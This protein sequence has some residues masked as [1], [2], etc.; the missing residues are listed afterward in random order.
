MYYYQLYRFQIVKEALSKGNGRDASIKG[1]ISS[2]L[3]TETDLAV[4]K[5]VFKELKEAYPNHK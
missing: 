3:V 1:D 5:F 4:E 2:D